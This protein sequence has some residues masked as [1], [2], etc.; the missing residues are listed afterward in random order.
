MPAT[1]PPRYLIVNADDFGQ[2]HGLNRGIIQ[3]HEQGIVTSTSLMV[4]WPAAR[5]A[6]DY[7]KR[8]P[9]LDAGLHLDLGEWIFRAG[10]WEPLYEVVRLEDGAAVRKEMLK[11]LDAFRAL[12]GADPSHLDSHQHVHLHE[13]VATVVHE[14][15]SAL[16]VPVRRANPEIGYCGSFYGQD[17]DGAPL[18][19]A[20]SLAGLDRILHQLPAGCTELCCHPGFAD[21]LQTMYAREREEE[22]RTLCHPALQKGIAGQGIRLSTFREYWP[23][24][25]HSHV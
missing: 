21:A 15:A 23:A 10:A 18:A 12:T 16:G 5:P 1:P 8:H 22:L 17:A 6:A 11:Q 9:S 19:E 7:L 14:I 13:P 24:R 3:A 20:I 25:V 2:S 4:R